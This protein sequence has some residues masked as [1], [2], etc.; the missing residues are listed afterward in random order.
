MKINLG[1]PVCHKDTM[2]N[3]EDFTRDCWDATWEGLSGRVW[4]RV[5][6]GLGGNIVLDLISRGDI[7][8][9]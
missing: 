1:E 6:S 3:G 8:G 5:W 9:D 7:H 4:N 2:S